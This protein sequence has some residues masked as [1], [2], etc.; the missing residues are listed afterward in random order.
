MRSL[1]KNKS[2]PKLAILTPGVFNSAYFE[3]VFLAQQMG[4]ELVEG[5]DLFVEN[6]EEL[7]IYF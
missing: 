1:S 6:I 5:S 2:N 7:M 3:H 4:V